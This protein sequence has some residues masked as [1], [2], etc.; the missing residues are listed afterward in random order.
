MWRIEEE[1]HVN[2]FKTTNILLRIRE[3]KTCRISKST[4]II[5][6]IK[7]EK[8]FALIFLTTRSKWVS[9]DSNKKKS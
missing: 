2:I 7:E 5:G 1:K 8:L 4:D 3:E 9:E 6:R